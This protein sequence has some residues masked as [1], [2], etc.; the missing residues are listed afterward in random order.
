MKFNNKLRKSIITG[1]KSASYDAK[2]NTYKDS[3]NKK[4]CDAMIKQKSKTVLLLD[5]KHM[6]STKFCKSIGINN[7][8]ITSVEKNIKI[9]NIHNKKINTIYGDIW[10]DVIS[11]ENLY[12]SYDTLILDA[13]SSSNTVSKNIENIFRNNYLS[14]KSVL[15]LTIT[16]R[17]NIKGSNCLTDFLNLKKIIEK[18]SSKYKYKCIWESE[19]EQSKVISVIYSVN[20]I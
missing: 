4:V 17:S 11:K 20:T 2:N 7:I 16:K 14:N 15:A 3:F 12:E 8:D 18:Y 1:K 5:G 9:H 13:V 6:R 19:Q 10:N